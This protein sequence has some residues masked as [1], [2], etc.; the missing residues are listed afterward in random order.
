MIKVMDVEE[1][2]E[3]TW[4]WYTPD[5]EPARVSPPAIVNEGVDYLEYFIVWDSIENCLFKDHKGS[6]TVTVH[7]NG[8]FFSGRK[9]MI[10]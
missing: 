8:K 7:V 9:F 10:H 5:G 1:K 2:M 6:W 4:R 3:V